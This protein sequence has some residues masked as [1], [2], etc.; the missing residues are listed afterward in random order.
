MID[1]NKGQTLKFSRD[2]LKKDNL[3]VSEKHTSNFEIVEREVEDNRGIDREIQHRSNFQTFEKIV[4]K[5]RLV[6]RKRGQTLKG[7]KD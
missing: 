5:N 6:D 3:K 7:L 4:E 2:S 1:R